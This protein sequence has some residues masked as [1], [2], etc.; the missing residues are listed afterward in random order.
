MPVELVCNWVL[1]WYQ[2]FKRLVNTLLAISS[3]DF[4]SLLGHNIWKVLLIHNCEVLGVGL[5]SST[6]SHPMNYSYSQLV[7]P[8][9]LKSM[10]CWI[11]YSTPLLILDIVI[12]YLYCFTLR[13]I[14]SYFILLKLPQKVLILMSWFNSIKQIMSIFAYMMICLIE[15][16]QL[17]QIKTFCG[18]F[19][20]MK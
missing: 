7:L 10:L 20:E 12:L 2:R 8:L 1:F 5:Q 6:W 3:F 19:H 4:F 18:S 9:S 17:I 15:L 16:N 13:F 11:F 14:F